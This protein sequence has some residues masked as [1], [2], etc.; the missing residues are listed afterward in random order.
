[1]LFFNN[2][3]SDR[4]EKPEVT[5]DKKS[6]SL[7]NRSIS[8]TFRHVLIDFFRRSKGCVTLLI[9]G[10]I[11][12]AVTFPA[13]PYLLGDI[14]DRIKSL[15]NHQHLFFSAIALPAILF[16]VI[17]F[18]RTLDYY[19]IGRVFA[20]TLPDNKRHIMRRLFDHLGGQS[21]RYFED[22]YS[23]LLSNKVNNCINGFEPAM[24][25]LFTVIFPQFLALLIS[26]FIMATVSWIFMLITW[27][28]AIGLIVYTY[29]TAKKAGNYSGEFAEAKSQ[30]NGKLVD[31]ISNIATV[32]ISGNL[33]PELRILSPALDHSVKKDRLLQYYMN[34]VQLIQGGMT[35]LFIILTML[36][37][38]IG[39]NRGWV[40]IGDFA[41][42]FALVF[43]MLG[44]VYSLGVN[45]LGFFKNVGQ[46]CEGLSLLNDKPEVVESSKPISPVL[47]NPAIKVNALKFQY[48]PGR[49]LFQELSMTAQAGEKVGLVGRS[50][51]GK[52]TLIKLLLR[53]YDVQAGEILINDNDIKNLSFESLRHQIAMVPQDL[54]L[55]HR[56]VFENIA[57][58]NQDV[59]LE[60][61]V[62]A[63][64]QARCDSFIQHLPEQYDTLVGERGVKLSGGQRQRIAIARAFLKNA[65]ILLLDEATSALDSET[66]AAIQASLD[67]LMKNKTAVVVAHR[68]STL[69]TMDRILVLDEG[70][71]VEEGTHETLLN[72][73][74]L[75]HHFW[76]HQSGGF[77]KSE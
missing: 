29:Q 53:L 6:K 71:I 42:I 62:Q 75:Y 37:L 59:P 16:I 19:M 47:K 17:N 20:V 3:S 50:G 2:E 54:M 41:F 49:P 65:P 31:F 15:G 43:Q 55:F 63:A 5:F 70:K 22:K 67:E 36:A 69:K 33:K 28:W 30:L 68:L 46:L 52:S 14:I 4:G 51:C 21:F 38:I 64:K 11:F 25:V 73:K 1:M 76:S 56:T 27:I 57:Y 39:Y 26:G 45:I 66:E 12:W 13:I 58:D 8:Y 9:L 44:Q 74:G 35:S 34:K 72:Q 24:T 10:G 48:E 18:L 77:L 40:S 32:L 61:V 23:G 7:P 60:S